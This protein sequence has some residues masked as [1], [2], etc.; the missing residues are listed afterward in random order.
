MGEHEHG[1]LV[2]T[3]TGEGSHRLANTPSITCSYINVKHMTRMTQ[4]MGGKNE[5]HISVSLSHYI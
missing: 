3:D 5:E 1:E 2:T 4:R